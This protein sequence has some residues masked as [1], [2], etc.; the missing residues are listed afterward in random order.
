MTDY[1]NQVKAGDCFCL[2]RHCKSRHVRLVGVMLD[3]GST[4]T[5]DLILTAIVIK[6]SHN[7]S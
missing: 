5:S 1:G 7:D 4:H 2:Y 6:L 3:V